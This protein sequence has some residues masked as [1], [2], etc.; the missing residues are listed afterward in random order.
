MMLITLI[1]SELWKKIAAAKED[2]AYLLDYQ[3]SLAIEYEKNAKIP[4]QLTKK[5]NRNF[6]YVL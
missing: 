4:Q 5:R 6:R 3:A 2:R 1:R